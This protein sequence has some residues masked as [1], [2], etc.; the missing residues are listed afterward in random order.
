MNHKQLLKIFNSH[1]S[2]HQRVRAHFFSRFLSRVVTVEVAL[3]Y[4]TAGAKGHS[5]HDTD[6]LKPQFDIQGEKTGL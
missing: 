2:A 3:Q 1:P 4:V 5:G 6:M